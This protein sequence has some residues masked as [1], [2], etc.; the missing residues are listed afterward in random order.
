MKYFLFEKIYELMAMART[1]P[2][3]QHIVDLP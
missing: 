2:D 1:V 3:Q